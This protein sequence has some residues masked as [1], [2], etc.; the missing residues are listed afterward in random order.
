MFKKP[1][2]STPGGLKR[3]SE[4]PFKKMECDSTDKK[5]IPTKSVSSKPMTLSQF[6]LSNH[7]KVHSSSA[8]KK[9]SLTNK[10]IRQPLSEKSARLIALALKSMLDA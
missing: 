5:S 7:K 9:H 2:N 1:Q 6:I 3:S 10:S 8:Q 4:N